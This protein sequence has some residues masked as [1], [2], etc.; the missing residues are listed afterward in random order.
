MKINIAHISDT[1]QNPRIMESLAFMSADVIVLTGD[2]LDNV[3]RGVS[4]RIEPR[5][6]A[7]K[8]EWWSRKAAKRWAPFIGDRP[9]VLVCGN[10]DFLSPAGWLRHYGVDVH[11]ITA[12]QPMIEIMGLRFAGFREVPWLAGEWA[13]EVADMAPAVERAL[14]CN[15]DILVTHAPP[16]G[17]LDDEEGYGVRALTSALSYTEH[18][19][20][21]HFF[22][23]C[24][25]NGGQA[26]TEMGI[27][28]ANGAGCCRLHTIEV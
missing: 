28:F 24:H 11:E 25:N 16:A 9:V 26:V 13:G 20:K 27:Y 1:H 3:G 17:I 5:R 15:P 7:R 10:H 2:I 8:Q 23:H 14:A 12:A 21:A 19:V 4:G 6:E 18:H 22:G